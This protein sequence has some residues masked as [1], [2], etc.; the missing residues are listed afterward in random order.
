MTARRDGEHE[1][2]VG[3]RQAIAH[4]QKQPGDVAV[5]RHEVQ[6]P[7]KAVE[8]R[9][10]GDQQHER[11]R[12][13]HEA[14]GDAAADAV[15][16]DLGQHRLV[17]TGAGAVEMSDEHDADEHRDQQPD[18]D[19]DRV[20]RACAGLREAGTPGTA[21]EITSIPVIAVAP[22]AKARST[23]STPRP[24]LRGEAPA[25]PG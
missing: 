25:G 10:G 8:G 11:G 9:V 6:Q 3:E 23:S 1:D 21:F 2:A 24:R 4:A 20:W 17:A 5:T 14:V 16:C 22:E 13:L 18:H 12:H 19:T 15:M 7:R